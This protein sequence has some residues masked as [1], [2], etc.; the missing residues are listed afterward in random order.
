MVQVAFTLHTSYRTRDAGMKLHI[1]QILQRNVP[2]L[3]Y[4]SQAW[5][6][7]TLVKEM[8]QDIAMTENQHT[9]QKCNI[10]YVATYKISL[11]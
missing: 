11:V 2:E 5:T 8:T 1:S 4:D 10:Q 9:D 6:G 3:G 7:P